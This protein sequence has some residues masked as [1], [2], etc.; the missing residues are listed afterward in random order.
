MRQGPAS[1]ATASR[2]CRPGGKA[3]AVPAGCGAPPSPRPRE[4]CQRAFGLF[5]QA[6]E[7][8]G[9]CP[10]RGQ[11]HKNFG[12]IYGQSGDYASAKRELEIAR[13]LLPD[14]DGVRRALQVVQRS[15]SDEN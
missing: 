12:I 1:I 6:L 2:L 11:I 14:D 5:R 10:A 13:D 3:P 7:V 8:C 4:E 15:A 9:G